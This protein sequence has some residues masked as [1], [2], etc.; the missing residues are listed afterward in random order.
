MILRG[1]LVLYAF[2]LSE[3]VWV[4]GLMWA[5][6]HERDGSIRHGVQVARE[7]RTRE[8]RGELLLQGRV[9]AQETYIL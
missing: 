6:M 3:V 7:G 4:A 8:A 9:R 1:C 2:R 5:D